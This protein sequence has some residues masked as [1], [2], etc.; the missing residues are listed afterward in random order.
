MKYFGIL[1]CLLFL[2]GC[3]SESSSQPAGKKEVF[4]LSSGQI[5][6]G[7]IGRARIEIENTGATWIRRSNPM[8]GS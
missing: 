1:F 6:D 2:C 4:G 5:E 7:L 8:T 3:T